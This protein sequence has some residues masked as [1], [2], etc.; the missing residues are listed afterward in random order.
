[1]D[2][3]KA[4]LART[5]QLTER[6]QQIVIGSLL[7]DGHLVH[8]TRGYAL[9]MNHG[10]QQRAYV[11]WKYEEL[12]NLT[13]SAPQ[14]YQRSYYFR[15]VS[16][17]YFDFLRTQFYQKSQKVVPAQLAQWMG[18]ITLAIWLMDDGS[19]DKYQLRLNSQSFSL[20][21]N[22]HLIRILEATFGITVT[23]NRDKQK[24]RLRVSARSMPRVRQLVA[25][26]IIPSMQYK[27]SP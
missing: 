23:V 14:T 19:R 17:P 10:I 21:E 16:H 3:L 8:T 2:T 1:M 5:V 25:P 24:F 20:Q 15:T 12:K 9:R 27:L 13:N 7:G 11:N 6:Q 4:K 18:P 26:F 22:K